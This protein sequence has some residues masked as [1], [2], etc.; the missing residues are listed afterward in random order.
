VIESSRHCGALGW[1]VSGAGGEGGSVTILCGPLSHEKRAMIR[2]IEQ[3]NDL[4]R[5]IPIY[6]SRYGLRSWEQTP[7]KR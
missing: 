1:R 4:F 2:E 7:R 5:D 6:L 3:T